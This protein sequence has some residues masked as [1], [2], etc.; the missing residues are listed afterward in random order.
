MVT[1]KWINEVN[2]NLEQGQGYIEDYVQTLQ[3]RG[4]LGVN[5]ITSGY[6]VSVC[7]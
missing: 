1:D 2:S 7:L 5:T 4:E 3:E 6:N